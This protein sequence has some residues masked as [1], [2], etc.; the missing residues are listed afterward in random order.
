MLINFRFVYED[1]KPTTGHVI[2]LQLHHSEMLRYRTKFGGH[3]S[4]DEFRSAFELLE[5]IGAPPD[6]S[7]ILEFLKTV[8]SDNELL[9]EFQSVMD[10]KVT[11]VVDR[12]SLTEHGLQQLDSHL[13]Q[14]DTRAH[15]ALDELRRMVMRQ[16]TAEEGARRQLEKQNRA[17]QQQN[18]VLQ[19]RTHQ[20]EERLG[21]LEEHMQA[22]LAATPSV[23]GA[24]PHLVSPSAPP[25]YWPHF[26]QPPHMHQPGGGVQW[27]GSVQTI[28][29]HH[30][31]R[32][33]SG[34]APVHR[35]RTPIATTQPRLM[36]LHH[37]G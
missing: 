6:D 19:K 10:S 4:Y 23:P 24:N 18:A 34:Q 33:G 26:N 12:M 17:L 8:G 14:S 36:N 31:Y 1:G 5:C 16:S 30:Y 2:E 15:E 21:K 35:S 7:D 11:E 22:A 20:L 3:H 29:H 27:D 28:H 37:S 13:K 25:G 9:S 32:H